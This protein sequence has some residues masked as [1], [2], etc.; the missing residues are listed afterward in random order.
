[1]RYYFQTE[2]GR[3]YPDRD[4]TELPDVAAACVESAKVLADFL[5]YKPRE[6]W[7]HDCLS[8]QVSDDAGLVLFT[9]NVSVTMSAAMNGRHPPV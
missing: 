1:M 9:L 6:L 5:K 7:A 2:D 3:C 8:V 4:G